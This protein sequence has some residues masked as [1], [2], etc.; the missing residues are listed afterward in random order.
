MFKNRNSA[1]VELVEKLAKYKNKNAIV[2]AIP[3]GGLPIGAVLAKALGLPLDIVLSKK[4]GHP[5]NQEFAIGSVSLD[6]VF[7]DENAKL[8]STE[9]IKKESQRIVND[10]QQKYKL[11]M[12]NKEPLN[13]KG[14]T[15]LLI[16]DGI[17]TGNTMIASLK[18]IK[19]KEPLKIIVVSP[20]SPPDTVRKLE[21]YADEV[22][23]LI[24]PE[25]FHS[26]S[27]FY[28][29]FSEVSDNEVKILLGT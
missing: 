8:V 22:I 13:I 28:E 14:K 25:G 7:L 24:I 12:G 26:T 9:Y 5:Y 15:V 6:G 4:I 2:L 21:K 27:E 17:A 23:C 1:A 11:L 19:K 20:V 10:L 16:D 18:T 3:R 29:D